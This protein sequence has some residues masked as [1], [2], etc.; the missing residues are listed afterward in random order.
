MGKG[1]LHSSPS[2]HVIHVQR[3][4]N[5]LVDSALF[6]APSGKRQKSRHAMNADEL[7][8]EVADEG[9]K[10]GPMDAEQMEGMEGETP[11]TSRQEPSK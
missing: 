6:L 10:T 2:L 7:P 3:K 9:W 8:Q 5:I 11:L 4:I 1:T